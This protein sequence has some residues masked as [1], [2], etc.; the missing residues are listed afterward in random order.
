MIYGVAIADSVE[1]AD[2]CRQLGFE[3]FQGY[4]FA[5]PVILQGR[6]ADPS[7]S[8]LLRL[9]QQSMS[10][11]ENAE[12]LVALVARDKDDSSMYIYLA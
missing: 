1:Q 12:K 8:V 5:R 6:R 2:H 3:L 4:F 9:L 7:R 11:V 10:N